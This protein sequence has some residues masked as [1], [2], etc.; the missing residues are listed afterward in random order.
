MRSS[1]AGWRAWSPKPGEG[2]MGDCS[3]LPFPRAVAAGDAAAPS[4]SQGNSPQAVPLPQ[5]LL[6]LAL[7]LLRSGWEAHGLQEQKPLLYGP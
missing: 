5:R 3:H 2:Q 4:R 1:S 7:V 6:G